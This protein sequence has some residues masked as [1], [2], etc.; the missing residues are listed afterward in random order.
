MSLSV[1]ILAA[2]KGKRMRTGL[3]K[4]LHA[5]AGVTLLER[6]VQTAHSLNPSTVYV[7]YGNGG[8]RVRHEM[9]HLNVTWVEQ[10]EALGTGHA[11]IQ[12]L[13]YFQ[14]DEQILILYGDVP[15]ISTETLQLLLQTTPKNALGIVVAEL[16]DPAGFGRIIR[17]E[18]GNIIRI[19]E[20]KDANPLQETIK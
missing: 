6:V 9:A 13:P 4:V 17:N 2:G 7:V 16:Q 14:Q 11:V 1:V 15:L 20:Q 19:V 18:M 3:P 8:A 12:A 5:L 10:T